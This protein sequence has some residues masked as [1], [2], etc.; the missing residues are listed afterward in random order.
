MN[1]VAFS[2][3]SARRASDVSSRRS[4]LPKMRAILQ[5]IEVEYFYGVAG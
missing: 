2:L 3:G 1:R 5:K 4:L